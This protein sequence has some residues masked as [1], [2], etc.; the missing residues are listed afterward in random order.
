VQIKQHTRAKGVCVRVHEKEEKRK[1]ET[2]KREREHTPV[3]MEGLSMHYLPLF[4]MARFG[5][6]VVFL[7]FSR[8]PCFVPLILVGV[9]VSTAPALVPGFTV[10]ERAVCA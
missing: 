7:F 9:C 10:L 1:K 6:V 3:I 2:K 4:K 8:A 5:D